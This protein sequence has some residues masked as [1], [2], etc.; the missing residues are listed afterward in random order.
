MPHSV[1]I[2]NASVLKVRYKSVFYCRQLMQSL[3]ILQ[4]TEAQLVYDRTF[5]SA[6]RSAEPFGRR[7]GSVFGSVTCRTFGGSA[8]PFLMEKSTQIGLNW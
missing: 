6:E 3:L 2:F 1:L 7:F 8:E 5:G 4:V